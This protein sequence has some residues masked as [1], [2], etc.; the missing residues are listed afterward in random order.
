M[1][2]RVALLLAIPACALAQALHPYSSP[3]GESLRGI[4]VVSDTVAWASGTHGTYLRTTDG[5][6]TWTAAQV[7]GAEKLDFRD[8]E[9][10]SA[11]EAYLLSAGP[12]DQSRIYKTTDAGQH[13][14]LQFTNRDAQGFYDCFAF[15]DERHGI[16][17]GDPVDQ[18]FELLATDD[19]GAHWTQLPEVSRPLAQPGEGAFAASGSCIAVSGTGHAWFATGG[20]TARVFRSTDRGRTWQSAQTPIARPS[21]SAGIFSIAFRDAVHGVIAGGDY[22]HPDQDGPNLATSEDG[23]VTWRAVAIHPQ[24]YFSAVTFL[25]KAGER[26]LA[27]GSSRALEVN[28]S[29]GSV[30]SSQPANLNAVSVAGSGKAIAV[31]AKGQIAAWSEAQAASSHP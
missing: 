27:V 9:A 19:G 29:R 24:F 7:P 30:V 5:G 28:L 20:G 8:V 2:L 25:D 16:A 1:L 10:F 17:L 11:D 21:S 13:W 18:H 15:W 12:G 14:T 26:V 23:G 6:K 22:Q 31:G 4:R 3:T